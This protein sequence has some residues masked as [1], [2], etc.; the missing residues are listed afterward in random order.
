[1]GVSVGTH[2]R[3]AAWAHVCRCALVPMCPREATGGCM[4]GKWSGR[5]AVGP[6]AQ[7]SVPVCMCTRVCEVLQ[8]MC[9]RGRVSPGVSVHACG[10]GVPHRGAQ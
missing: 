3:R 10:L 2:G 9:V 7:G 8:C 4:K 1:M 5:V 6:C